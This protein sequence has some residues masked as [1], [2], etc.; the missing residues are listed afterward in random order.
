MR[1]AGLGW[2][3]IGFSTLYLIGCGDATPPFDE[4]PLRDA[5][6]ADPAT[7]AALDESARQRLAARFAAAV[8]DDATSDAV[9]E[10]PKAASEVRS[11]DEARVR[12]A[13]DALVVGVIA[14]GL[15]RPVAGG[16]AV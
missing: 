12:R 15:A 3:S 10:D 16:A 7:V 11:L 1:R 6:R 8:T 13:A 4:L 9:S 14:G 5:L 2:L